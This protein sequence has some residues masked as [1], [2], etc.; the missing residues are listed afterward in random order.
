VT[1]ISKEALAALDP[2]LDQVLDLEPDEREIWFAALRLER[3]VLAGELESLLGQ[4]SLLEER[5][6]LSGDGYAGMFDGAPSLIGLQIG[7]YTLEEPIGQGGMGSVWLGRRSDGRFKGKAAVK[8]LNLALVDPIGVE[9]FRREGTVLAQLTHP[10]IAR[11]L[12][13][14]LAEAG[15]PYLVLEYVEGQRIDLYCD[16]HQLD[17]LAR[18][19]LFRQ[20]AGAVAH[21]HANLIVHRDLKP[22]NILVSPDGNVKLLDFGIAKLLESEASGAERSELTARGGLAFTPEYAAPEQV[23]GGPI[24]TAT[25][26][27]SL[28][29]LLYLLLAGRHPTSG[30]SVTT[31][32]HL[33]GILDTEPPRLSVAVGGASSARLK[34]LYR[35]DLD[36][37][38]A[39]ALKKEPA[40]RYPTVTAL[41]D[42]L[43]RHLRHE[44]VQARPDSYGYRARKFVRRNRAAV[45]VSSLTAAALVVATVVTASQMVEARKQRD[46]AVFQARRGKAQMEFQTLLLS[47]LGPKPLTAREI[48]DRGRV[49]LEREWIGEP[50]FTSGITLNLASHYRQLGDNQKE[51]ELLARAESLALHA[52]AADMLVPVRCA[53]VSNIHHRDSTA[54][55]LALLDR[56]RSLFS[57]ADRSDVAGCLLV[58]ADIA[59][60]TDRADTAVI[61]GRRALGLLDS[62]GD[63]T[64]MQYIGAL[65]SLANALENSGRG[66]EAIMAYERINDVLD[67]SGRRESVFHSVITNNI[68]IALSNLGE[69]N[70]AEPVLRG[71]VEEFQRSDPTGFVHPA[72]LVNY[73]RT[74]LFLR[75]LDT[76]GF[77]YDRMVSQA[78]AQRDVE[79]QQ[80][81]H[82]GLALVEA[83]RGRLS[84]AARH[85][86]QAKRFGAT[87]AQ[88][89]FADNLTLAGVIATARGNPTAGLASLEAALRHRGYYE[90]KRTYPMRA[91]LV[92]AAEAA[93]ASS[94]AKK[95][96]EYA[97]AARDVADVDSLTGT[98]SAYVGEAAL[99]ESRGLLL[100]G[101][102]VAARHQARMAQTAL[103]FGAGAEHP[104]TLEAASLSS[105]LATR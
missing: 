62:L 77:W 25:D 10:N 17:P 52:G 79:M 68:G 38:L 95:A 48:L 101:D 74:M 69:M 35:G 57:G 43:E 63:T 105:R 86:E 97:R 93:L 78:A 13:A 22:S 76:A 24:T 40:Q 60:F 80:T 31:A 102:S 91:E 4:E 46:E 73:N 2:L 21:A 72:I 50:R 90:G 28:G 3:P 6:F 100:D 14:G 27:Y 39:K 56:T 8:L 81:G 1:G 84:E 19:A 11:M 82:Y 58:E 70:A 44:P 32:G 75:K 64:G 29:V 9:R 66:R 92:F 87:L 54:R 20:V 23:L 30:G 15:Q 5:G 41:A 55:A 88:P 7:A 67:R 12:D 53:Q 18:L 71:T 94:N 47:S 83:M 45:L 26:V 104:R 16:R 98:R 61:L 99:L 96:I 85:A 51:A 59:Y 37:I 89:R 65:N 33:S 36:N 42:D 34:R 49:L 103:T